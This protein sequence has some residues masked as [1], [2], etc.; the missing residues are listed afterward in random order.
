MSQLRD[1]TR[2]ICGGVGRGV[3]PP[4]PNTSTTALTK[5]DH[6]GVGEG[7]GQCTG[8]EGDLSAW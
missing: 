4:S 1:V 5:G 8:P 3:T 2:V 7:G 6:V